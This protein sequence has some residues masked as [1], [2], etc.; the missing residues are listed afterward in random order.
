[1]IYDLLKSENFAS[2]P[3]PPVATAL[4]IIVSEKPEQKKNEKLFH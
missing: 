3:S 4:G 1:M 2:W